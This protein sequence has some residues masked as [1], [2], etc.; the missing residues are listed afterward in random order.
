MMMLEYRVMK[1]KMWCS[2]TKVL[3]TCYRAISQEQSQLSHSFSCV[4]D[5]KTFNSGSSGRTVPQKV[6]RG[7]KI[8][9]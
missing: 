3:P 2:R 5:L 8:R 9:A 6:L 7:L 4:K 1:T